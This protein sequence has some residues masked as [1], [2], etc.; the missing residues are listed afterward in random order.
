MQKFVERMI[1]ERDDLKGKI[2]RANEAIANPP[3]GSDEEDMKMLSMQVQAMET[4]LFWLE[5]RI[6]KKGGK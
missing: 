5:K 2:K 4:Y 1:T 3:F 6:A